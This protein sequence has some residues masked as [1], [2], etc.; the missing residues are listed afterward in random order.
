MASG[1]IKRPFESYEEFTLTKSENATEWTILRS[2][3]CKSGRIAFIQLVVQVTANQ[4]DL[5]VVVISLPKELRPLYNFE[6]RITSS[7]Q[8]IDINL[9]VYTNGEVRLQ[10]TPTLKLGNARLD[11]C[12]PTAS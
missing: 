6:S 9:N 4:D 11:F 2:H 12:Y 5:S 1:N 10:R 3:A 7:A 8:S